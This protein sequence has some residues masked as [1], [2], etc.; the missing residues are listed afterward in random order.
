MRSI[1]YKKIANAIEQLCIEA[2]HNLPCDVLS[3]LE[4]SAKRESNP[5]AKRVIETLIENAGI[6]KSE[7]IPLCQTRTTA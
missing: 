2:A 1:N 4:Q 5:K 7:N 3:A 6:A